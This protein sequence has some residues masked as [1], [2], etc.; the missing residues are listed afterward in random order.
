MDIGYITSIS[1]TC[2]S[3]ACACLTIAV[4][5]VWM[6]ER[7]RVRDIRK[8][9]PCPPSPHDNPTYAKTVQEKP[10]KTSATTEDTVELKISSCVANRPKTLSN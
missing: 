4:C 8:G 6:C 7:K 9:K 10:S 2:I 3:L 5:V 1:L